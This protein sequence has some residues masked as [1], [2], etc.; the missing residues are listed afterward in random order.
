M[1]QEFNDRKI[2]GLFS[3]TPPLEAL[4]ILLADVSH[5]CGRKTLMVNDVSRAFFYA[6]SIRDTYVEIPAEGRQLGDENCIHYDA[7]TEEQ[8]PEGG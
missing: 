4:R 6:K 5:S 2:D 8:Q 3:A 1:A 7:V